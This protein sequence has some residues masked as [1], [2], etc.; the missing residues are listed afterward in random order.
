MTP[1]TRTQALIFAN[2]DPNDGEMVRRALAAAPDALVI[3]ADGGARIA[4]YF[5]R[6]LDALIGDMDSVT[7]EDLERA[8]D[9]GAAILRHPAAKNE[10]DLEL[11]LLYAAERGATWIRV[12]GAV[13][14]RLDQTLSNAYL[15][16]LPALR[17]CDARLVAGK[18]EAWLAHPGTTRIEGAPGDTV[19]LIPL[20]GAA[21]EVRT[22][23][24]AYPLR[25]E[26]L[27][28]GPARG[29]SNVLDAPSATVHLGEGVLLIVH[30]IGRA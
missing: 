8:Q 20:T 23:G 19:S 1:P 10:T 11:A 5:G 3:A 21:Q 15:L 14:D 7:A 25:G 26:T 18:Q 9:G 6:G 13:G 4:R 2:G 29:V 24:L 22:E 27:I 16:A 28:F 17:G 12:I 30:T